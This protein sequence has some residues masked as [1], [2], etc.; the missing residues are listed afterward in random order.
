MVAPFVDGVSINCGC[1]QTWAIQE[2]LGC[3]LMS[4][5]ER[6]RDM[7]RAIRERCGRGLSVGVKIRVHVD[8]EE[9]KRWV[10]IVLGEGLVDY[11]TVHGRTRRQRSS[12]VPNF[13]A[14]R[15]IRDLVK[16]E[17]G[18]I[19]VV[20]NG[21]VESL[22]AEERI[23]RVTGVDGVMT[24]RA[25]LTNP[26]LFAGY[27]RT[28][29]GAVERCVSYCLKM[30]IPYPLAKYHV[31]EMLSEVLGRKERKNLQEQKCWADL[32]DWLDDKFV[33]LRE[34]EEGWGEGVEI[35]RRVL[36]GAE[37]EEDENG[38]GGEGESDAEPEAGG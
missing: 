16:E 8:V 22:E 33:L 20:A 30:P 24:A 7:V 11:I 26:A 12:E 10:R 3:A 32:L 35:P 34:G 13:A 18:G 17:L 6:V 9:T 37:D 19:P 4:D 36:K 14:I 1:P 23:V 31:G 29:W 25:L 5:P 28:P 21:D 27:K 38:D 15:V 2:G